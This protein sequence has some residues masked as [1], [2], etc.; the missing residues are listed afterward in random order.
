M[1]VVTV[2]VSGRRSSSSGTNSN[3]RMVEDFIIPDNFECLNDPSK[4]F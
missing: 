3:K 4:L 2:T 1:Y